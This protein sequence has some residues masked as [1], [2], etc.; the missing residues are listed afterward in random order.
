LIA[1]GIIE[2]VGRGRGVRYMLSRKFLE[3]QGLPGSYT[4]E[5]ILAAERACLALFATQALAE[6]ETAEDRIR[7]I[8]AEN[9][10]RDQAFRDLA[11]KHWRDGRRML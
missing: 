6:Q 1:E 9:L 10:R 7:R 4:R 8:D 3:M 2:R 11:A 5:R